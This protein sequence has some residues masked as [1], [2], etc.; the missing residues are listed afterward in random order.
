ML[1][2][3]VV[4]FVSN[5]D[6]F[7]IFPEAVSMFVLIRQYARES[8]H[9]LSVRRL[10]HSDRRMALALAAWNTSERRGFIFIASHD[11]RK[12]RGDGMEN[13]LRIHFCKLVPSR[14]FQLFPTPSNCLTAK[15]QAMA[16]NE[17][18]FGNYTSDPLLCEV[19]YTSEFRGT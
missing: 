15:G 19:S 7:T 3:T 9:S 12:G 11:M 17:S 13:N 10:Y 14:P 5:C 6:L 2:I 1:N 4:E 16:G 18:S 8:Y